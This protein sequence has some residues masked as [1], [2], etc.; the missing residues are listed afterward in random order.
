MSRAKTLE[1]RIEAL[2]QEIAELKGENWC[3]TGHAA[4]LMHISV[5]SI[6]WRIRTKPHIYRENRCWKWNASKT[7]L[8][9]NVPNWRKA[10]A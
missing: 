1:Q 9:I 10:D 3:K 8:L 2:E 4:K 5:Q 7:Q 6:H